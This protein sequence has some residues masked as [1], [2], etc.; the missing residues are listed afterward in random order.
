MKILLCHNF[1]RHPGGEDQ[2][3]DDESWLL[4]KS[5]HEVIR[6]ERDNKFIESMSQWQL[7]KTTVWSRRTYEALSR[8]INMHR[9]RIVHFHNTFPLISPSGYEAAQRAGVPVVQTLHN[10]RPICPAATLLRNNR[11]CESCTEKLVA[12][13]GI[14]HG[15]YRDS[16]K[17]TAVA[18]V[19]SA[20]HQ[21][22]GTWRNRIDRF[23]TLTNH[24]RERFISAGFPANKLSVKPNFVRPDPGVAD[25]KGDYAIFV[26]R[27]SPEKGIGTLLEA[28]R[29]DCRTIPLRIIGDGPLR[30]NV[31]EVATKFPSI[32]WLGQL[33]FHDVLREI[34]RA[35]VLISPSIWYETF[36]RS[37]IEA[38]AVGTPV[39]VSDIGAMKELVDD[40]ITGMHFRAGDASDLAKKV[41]AAFRDEA[42]F[43]RARQAARAE[44]EKKYTAEVNYELL[45]DIYDQAIASFPSNR[46]HQ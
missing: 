31:L 25:T 34:G 45:M 6:L 13:P 22:R 27:L 20:F 8:M 38:F 35:R 42:F 46:T 9:P 26:G 44:Y 43:A 2:V 4:E 29:T 1:Y 3:Y 14:V 7:A 33:P 15:C 21:L 23:I 11:P 37:M 17:A 30:D 36:G 40:R 41:L 24:S 39:I 5:G 32:Q 12:W 10:F 19:S 16:R 18:A 28:W